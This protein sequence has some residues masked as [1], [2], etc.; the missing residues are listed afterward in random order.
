MEY[1]KD[2]YLKGSRVNVT[3]ESDDVITEN[4]TGTIVGI[5]DFGDS[6]LVQVTEDGYDDVW[7]FWPHQIT[8]CTDDIM[9]GDE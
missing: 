3:V 2:N 5:R 9:H 7:D 8:P 6:F 1:E 4:F